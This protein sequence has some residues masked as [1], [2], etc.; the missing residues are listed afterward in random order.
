MDQQHKLVTLASKNNLPLSHNDR[1]FFGK[2]LY[3]VTIELYAYKY[4]DLMYVQTI[5]ANGWKVDSEVGIS[6]LTVVRNYAKKHG[7]RTRLEYKT[8]TYYTS[9]LDRLNEITN[10]VNRLKNKETTKN[11]VEMIDIS[12]IRYFPGNNT[13]RNIHYRKKRLPYSIYKFKLLGNH[14]SKEEYYEWEKWAEQY[15]NDIKLPNFKYN[16]QWGTWAGE[17]IGY[18]SSEKVLQLVHFKLGPKINKIIEYQIKDT[19]S[20]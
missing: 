11:N 12:A 7:D 1:L 19:Y 18:V 14:M 2:Y 17:P 13:E 9:D 6:F 3:R 8:L 5:D 16:K 15:P 20:K 4:P 10:Y